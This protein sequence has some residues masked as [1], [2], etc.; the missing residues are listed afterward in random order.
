MSSLGLIWTGQ[1]AE[2]CWAELV[3]Q[4]AAVS[5]PGLSSFFQQ[6]M[7]GTLGLS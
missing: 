5:K 2:P 1:P 3:D 7:L 4:L 6:G